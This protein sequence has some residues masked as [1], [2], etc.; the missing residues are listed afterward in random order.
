M[1]TMMLVLWN[2][3][4]S[5]WQPLCDD[6][7][8]PATLCMSLSQVPEN[9]LVESWHNKNILFCVLFLWSGACSPLLC[10]EPSFLFVFWQSQLSRQTL[11]QCT[12]S[13]VCNHMHQHLCAYCKSQTLQLY[14][15]LHIKI[16]HTPIGKGN[17]VVI[18]KGN[19]AAKAT[20]VPAGDINHVGIYE[21]RSLFSFNITVDMVDKSMGYNVCTKLLELTFK[22]AYRPVSFPDS[23]ADGCELVFCLSAHRW[24]FFISLL[25]QAFGLSKTKT[26]KHVS[27]FCFSPCKMSMSC[28]VCGGVWPVGLLV[29]SI[30]YTDLLMDM[31]SSV[32]FLDRSGVS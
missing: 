30:D 10:K 12:Y 28:C 31:P 7:S 21:G 19:A 11:L 15:C 23:P 6:S 32:L 1:L 22:Q 16:L 3:Y 2:L 17:A 27:F 13:L 24:T 5:I 26:E 4:H 8:L 18:G 29:Y 14:H 9:L 20:W 25:L